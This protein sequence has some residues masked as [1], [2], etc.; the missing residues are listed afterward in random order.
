MNE[1][2]SKTYQNLMWYRKRSVK[3]EVHSNSCLYQNIIKGSNKWSVNSSQRPRKQQQNK[4]QITRK[5][6]TKIKIKG[7]KWKNM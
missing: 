3:K 4:P 2:E 5:I 6:I 1:V 7:T